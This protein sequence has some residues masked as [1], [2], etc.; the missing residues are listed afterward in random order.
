[1]RHD[2]DI[3]FVAETRLAVKKKGKLDPIPSTQL[4]IDN[5]RIEHRVNDDTKGGI[6]VYVKNANMK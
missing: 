1:M 5:Y 4:K 2:F 3:F 6:L